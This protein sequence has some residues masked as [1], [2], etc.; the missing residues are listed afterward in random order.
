[1][2]L[3]KTVVMAIAL[4]SVLQPALSR[5]DEATDR[6]VDRTVQNSSQ[7]TAAT[8]YLGITYTLLAAAGL[9]ALGVA[10]GGTA[11]G[12][13]ITVGATPGVATAAAIG[14]GAAVAGGGTVTILLSSGSRQAGVVALR[15]DSAAYLASDGE[16][17]SELLKMTLASLRADMNSQEKLSSI[18]PSISDEQMVKAIIAAL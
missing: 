3:K 6:A 16:D 8:I 18:S 10:V 7:A 5:A 9:G 12:V 13:A 11:Y 1:M 2:N 17:T 4:I 15:E 14:V